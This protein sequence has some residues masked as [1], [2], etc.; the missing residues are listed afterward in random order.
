MVQESIH[1]AGGTIPTPKPPDIAGNGVTSTDE[2]P[3]SAGGPI[4]STDN[5]R[6]LT[7]PSPSMER[8]KSL[9]T[10]SESS[11]VEDDTVANLEPGKKKYYLRYLASNTPSTFS[12]FRQ[13]AQVGHISMLS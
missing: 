8:P 5:S 10:K 4:L 2:P 13:M 6:S 9:N 1:G 7:Q 11:Y 3:G 12:S